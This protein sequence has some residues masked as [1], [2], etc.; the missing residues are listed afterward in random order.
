[1]GL[2]GLASD[3]VPIDEGLRFEAKRDVRLGEDNKRKEEEYGL[4]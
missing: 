1:M 4:G 2:H 3:E